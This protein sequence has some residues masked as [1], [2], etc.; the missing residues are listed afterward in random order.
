M[1]KTDFEWCEECQY[2]D[3]VAEKNGAVLAMNHDKSTFIRYCEM[4]RDSATRDGQYDAA[5]HIQH[6]LDDLNA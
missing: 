2:I 1:K 6:V 3:L 5:T 4:Q